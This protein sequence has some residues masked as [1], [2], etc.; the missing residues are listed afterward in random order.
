LTRLEGTEYHYPVQLFKRRIS[1]GEKKTSDDVKTPVEGNNRP[2]P[3][4]DALFRRLRGLDDRLRAI[5]ENVSILKRDL[6]RIDR[7]GYREKEA[8]QRINAISLSAGE[9]GPWLDPWQGIKR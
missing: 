7:A 8:A 4:I 6:A 2:M 5:E 9:D 3:A 1:A